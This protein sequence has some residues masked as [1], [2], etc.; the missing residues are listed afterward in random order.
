MTD[1]LQAVV[2]QLK[3]KTME[4]DNILRA[5]DEFMQYIQST[6]IDGV[7]TPDMWSCFALLNRVLKIWMDF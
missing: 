7:Y 3:Q 2:D 5:R 1:E 4:S 6:W